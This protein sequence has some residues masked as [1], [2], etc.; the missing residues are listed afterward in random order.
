[1]EKRILGKSNLALSSVGLG[2]WQLGGDFGNKAVNNAFGILDAAISNNINF[3]DTADVYGDGLS[4]KIIGKFCVD[5]IATPVIASKV[6]RSSVLYPNNYSKSDLRKNIEGT[7]QRLQIDSLDLVQLHCIPYSEMKKDNIWLTLEDFRNEGLIKYYG[8]SVETI[9]EGLLCIEKPGLTSIQVIF[10][11]FRQDLKHLL[12]PKAQKADVGVIVR[13]PLAS[14]L[15]SGKFDQNTQFSVQDHRNY[16][17]DG[18]YFSVGETFSGISFKKGLEL[19]QKLRQILPNS[20]SMAQIAI[21]WILDHPQVTSVISGA[22]TPRQVEENAKA[23]SLEPLPTELHV[24]LEEF[25]YQKVK[26]NIRGEI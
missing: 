17:S 15:L 10:N 4:E 14:G 25:Y 22:S 13:L 19:T 5:R 6:G 18:K 26:T 8:A 16:N 1:M 24:K 23:A 3:W 21:R 7:L 12:L 2:C 20:P 9:E 11:I